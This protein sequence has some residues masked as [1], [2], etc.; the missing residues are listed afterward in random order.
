MSREPSPIGPYPRAVPTCVIFIVDA[1]TQTHSAPRCRNTDM[2]N[3]GVRICPPLMSPTEGCLGPHSTA[4]V[5]P[6]CAQ[7]FPGLYGLNVSLQPKEQESPPPFLNTWTSPQWSRVPEYS[8]LSPSVPSTCNDRKE[9][10]VSVT[11]SSARW[12]Q[13]FLLLGTTGR[14]TEGRVESVSPKED[15]EDTFGKGTNFSRRPPQA[16]FLQKTFRPLQRKMLP[17]VPLGTDALPFANA[18]WKELVAGTKR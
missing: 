2:R 15:S 7:N 13:V 10:T 6:P 1:A 3:Q 17:T 14:H 16:M 4:L 18:P 12:P 8:Q 11:A 5:W 9:N